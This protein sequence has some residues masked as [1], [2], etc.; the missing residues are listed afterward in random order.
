MKQSEEKIIWKIFISNSQ[1]LKHI[2]N[3]YICS[4]YMTEIGNRIN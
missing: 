3:K 1:E 2:I 4:I